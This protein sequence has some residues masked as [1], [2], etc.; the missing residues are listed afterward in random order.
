M[1]LWQLMFL[2]CMLTFI[3]GYV[4]GYATTKWNS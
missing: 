2:K 1:S 4:V 3:V